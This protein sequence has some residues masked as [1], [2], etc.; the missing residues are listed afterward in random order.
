M[1]LVVNCVRKCL[2]NRKT[3]QI[4]MKRKFCGKLSSDKGLRAGELYPVVHFMIKKL[5]PVSLFLFPFI[6]F[7]QTVRLNH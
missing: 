5:P 2:T 6:V 4:K 7:T 3:L 1:Y